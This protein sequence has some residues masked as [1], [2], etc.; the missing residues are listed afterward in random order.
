MRWQSPAARA[1]GFERG[2]GLERNDH[3]LQYSRD[4]L[5]MSEASRGEKLLKGFE[6]RVARLIDLGIIERGKGRSCMLS[7][8]FY[9]FVCKKSDYTRKKGLGRELN[10][11]LRKKHI[12]ENAAV[13]SKL[14]DVGDRPARKTTWAYWANR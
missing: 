3:V 1:D 11:T 10:L 4:W 13:G 5:M 2:K 7:R 14:D 8:R 6:I 12:D 9:E